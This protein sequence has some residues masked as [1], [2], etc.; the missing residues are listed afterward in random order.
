MDA[1]SLL[2]GDP[3]S[4]IESLELVDSLT[5]IE[6]HVKLLDLTGERQEVVFPL[7]APVPPA[8]GAPFYY[9]EL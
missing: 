5:E 9:S 1:L 6:L 7:E 3:L 2:L 8:M 4:T